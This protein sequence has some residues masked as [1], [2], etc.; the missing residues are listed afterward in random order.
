ML[1]VRFPP[2]DAV[3]V[4]TLC[5]QILFP[6]AV[7]R[8]LRYAQL[9]CA[10]AVFRCCVCVCL[11]ADAM[12]RCRVGMLCADVDLDADRVQAGW[13]G[14]RRTGSWAGDEGEVADRWQGQGRE[15]AMRAGSRAGEDWVRS[16]AGDEGG[17]RCQGHR[18]ATRAGSRAGGK[19]RVTSGRR[20][21]GCGQKRQSKPVSSAESK[22]LE[23]RV[24]SD[25]EVKGGSA[26]PTQAVLPG[27][28]IE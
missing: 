3:S 4:C 15:R 18:Q 16:R 12:C 17:R 2:A 25:E 20:R 14:G 24:Q 10:Y 21:Q 7:C 6:D 28:S 8:R 23:H 9:L 26:S 27:G 11:F 1:C 13:L 5:V 19:G 22:R